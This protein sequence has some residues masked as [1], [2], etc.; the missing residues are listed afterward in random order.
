M[1]KSSQRMLIKL[2]NKKNYTL[3][4][5]KLFAAYMVVFIHIPF[6][7]EF[8]NIIDALARFAVP[9]FFLISGFYSYN[10]SLN[11]IKKR[12]TNTMRLFIISSLIYTIWNIVNALTDSNTENLANYFNRYLSLKTIFN[13]LVLNIPVSSVHLWYILALLY[14]YAIFYFI[15]KKKL[16]EKTFFRI[17]AFLLIMN[18]ILGEFLLAIGVNI[19]VA[20]IRN[21][22]FTG[23]PFFGFGILAKKY[24]SKLASAKTSTIITLFALGIAEALISRYLF[25]I[26]EIYI[27]TILIISA[28]VVIFIKYSDKKYPKILISLANNSTYIYILHIIVILATLELISAIAPAY[29]FS[30]AIQMIRPLIVCVISTILAYIVNGLTKKLKK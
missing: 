30:V 16:K 17:C 2:E 18:L 19:S 27:G 14:V 7:G 8:G 29:Q 13:F 15:T 5:L 9:L 4:I 22:L 12:I 11:K 28:F 21:F 6:Y 24:E 23:L 20:V 25:G 26:N 10:I 3:E 1:I